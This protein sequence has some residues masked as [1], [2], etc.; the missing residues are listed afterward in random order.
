M[1]FD[2]PYTTWSLLGYAIVN[3]SKLALVRA[4]GWNAQYARNILDMSDCMD[5]LVLRLSEAKAMLESSLEQAGSDSSSKGVSQ[6]FV[7]LPSTLERVKN[8]HQAMYMADWS[9]TDQSLS[10]SS[11]G[12]AANLN[13]SNLIM[14]SSMP[15][16]DFLDEDFWQYFM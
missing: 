13:A 10:S 16:L 5:T 14:P 2:L 11:A 3:L 7:G 12:T 9:T 15:I 8:A 1:L 4:D 6:F